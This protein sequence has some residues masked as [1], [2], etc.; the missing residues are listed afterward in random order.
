[1]IGI[2]LLFVYFEKIWNPNSIQRPNISFQSKD[3]IFPLKQIFFLSNWTKLEEEK[4]KNFFQALTSE[5]LYLWKKTMLREQWN[6]VSLSVVDFEN[7]NRTCSSIVRDRRFFI[8]Q[9][10]FVK[11][12]GSFSK[13]EE[14]IYNVILDKYIKIEEICRKQNLYYFH[15]A[16]CGG[17]TFNI[18]ASNQFCYDFKPPG[19]H[20][21]DSSGTY[22]GACRWVVVNRK[23]YSCQEL[24]DA[25]TTWQDITNEGFLDTCDNSKFQYCPFFRYVTTLREPIER[26]LAHF[27]FTQHPNFPFLLRGNATYFLSSDEFLRDKNVDSR[28]R[29]IIDNFMTRSFTGVSM[30]YDA[31]YDSLNVSVFEDARENLEQFEVIL[32][33]EQYPTEESMDI[34]RQAVGWSN[35]SL[36]LR[37]KPRQTRKDIFRYQINNLGL[38]DHFERMIEMAKR[39]NMW[40]SKLYDIAIKL[41]KVDCIFYNY[42]K[43]NNPFPVFDT[44]CRPR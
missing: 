39:Y 30:Y 19:T 35:I 26:L 3:L 17:T 22:Y 38:N 4:I 23:T 44:Q 27:V 31:P 2:L 33:S 41:Y 32:L 16:R 34:I 24:K 21:I 18:V 20:R 28:L 40:D 13:Q 7:E 9:M 37:E 29:L 14:I 15:V 8:F 43:I 6:Q 12:V 25:T 42:V 10:E 36:F 1:L 5:K 11:Q